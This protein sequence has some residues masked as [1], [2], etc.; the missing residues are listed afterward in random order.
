MILLFT[1][2]FNAF[3]G[4]MLGTW[5]YRAGIDPT[6]GWA[7]VGAYLVWCGLSGYWAGRKAA[8]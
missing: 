8:P 3:V 5:L 4:Y 1:S 6:L 7:I 2:V